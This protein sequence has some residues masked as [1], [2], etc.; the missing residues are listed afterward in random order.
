MVER[1]HGW[2]NRF[3]RILIQ[4]EKLPETFTAMLHLTCDGS[5]GI[6]SK[7]LSYPNPGTGLIR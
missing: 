7:A 2:M 3:R 6:G 4:W 1:T 5:S